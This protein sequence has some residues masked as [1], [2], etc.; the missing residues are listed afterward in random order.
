MIKNGF[1]VQSL[2]D[3]TA[4]LLK[5]GLSNDEAFLF[6]L[7][8]NC[9]LDIHN[10]SSWVRE[11]SINLCSNGQGRS[12]QQLD[13]RLML[14]MSNGRVFSLDI[15]T[16]AVTQEFSVQ[17]EVTRFFPKLMARGFH[18]HIIWQHLRGFTFPDADRDDDGVVDGL[19]EFPDDPNE[20]ADL[21]GD[22][23]GDN[24]DWAPNDASETMD[25]DNEV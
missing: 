23:V 25:S 14:G 7:T 18:L 3:S 5:L 2:A 6:S 16:L 13:Q 11:Q 17:G 9:R 4:P 21:D 20:S 12:L 15:D 24:A 19:D 10:T 8:D 22:G 1:F